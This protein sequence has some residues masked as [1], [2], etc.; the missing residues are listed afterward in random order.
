MIRPVNVYWSTSLMTARKLIRCVFLGLTATTMAGLAA[1]QAADPPAQP[2]SAAPISFFRDIRPILQANCQGCH[3]PA[4][5]QGQLILTSHAALLKA[6]ESG[7]HAIVPG[8]PE[9]SHLLAQ[10]TPKDGKA[11]M[12]KDKDPLSADQIDRLRRWIAAG[13]VDDT[14]PSVVARIDADHPPVYAA[15]P[16]ITSLD[17]S[18]DDALLAV[19]GYHE[20]LLYKGD[21]SELVARLVGESERIESAAFSPDGKSLAVAGGSPG[22]LGELQVWDVETRKLRYSVAVTYDTLYGASWTARQQQNR[23]RLRRQHRAGHR[24]GHRQAGVCFRERT[25]TGCSTRCSRRTRAH[26]IS[27]SRDRSMKLI[28]VATQRFRRQY[29]QHHA[30]CPQGRPGGSRP[31]SEQRRTADRR[32]RRSA[33]DLP[34]VSHQGPR[35]RRRFQL[36]QGLRCE[37]RT[38]LRPAIQPRRQPLCRRQQLWTGRAK[39]GSTR[40]PAERCCKSSRIRA[41]CTAVTYS[42]DGKRVASG[43]FDGMVRIHDAENG[44]LVKEFIAAPLTP[45]KQ[46]AGPVQP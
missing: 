20:V 2:D 33:Q 12:P 17:Y 22:R 43:G 1:V 14:P 7:E 41:P 10:V 4:K 8:K 29:H 5:P 28:E 25:A 40:R 24:C 34:D 6:G 37:C 39:C 3:Q 31:E 16:V 19:S 21:G 15:P 45:A 18:P 36:D 30:G 13:A 27:V 11:E 23:L 26:V 44:Q 35:H 9:A 38:D 32:G 46:V 42:A